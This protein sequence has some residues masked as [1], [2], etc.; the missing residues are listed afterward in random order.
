MEPFLKK[1][2]FKGYF[3]INCIVDKDKIYPLE[4]TARLGQPTVHV[5]NAL[6]DSPWGEFMKAIAD[7]KDYNFKYKNGFG[8]VVFLGT[9]PYPYKSRLNHN[10]PKGLEIFLKEKLTVEEKNNVHLE[11]V[12]ILRGN[13]KVVCG[14]SGYIAHIAGFGKNVEEA[15]EKTYN[16]I[17]KIVIPKVFY[18]DDIGL[19]FIERGKNLLKKY[20]W[21]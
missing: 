11:E 5:Q 7:G 2:K 14:N 10:S 13:R 1:I 19:D 9:P 6:I 17:K 15:R 20:K 18:R 3:D 12:S 16:L 8:I 21:I 4:A